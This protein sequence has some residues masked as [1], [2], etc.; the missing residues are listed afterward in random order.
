MVESGVAFRSRLLQM[1][2]GDQ[3]LFFRSSDFYAQNGFKQMSIVE[4]Y[5]LVARMR[6]T[7]RIGL[8]SQP[9][10]TSARRWIKRGILRTTII[11]QMCVIAYRLGFSDQTIARLYRRDTQKPS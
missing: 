9:V 7:G 3:A 4:D 11:N 5:E 2:Y 1:P 6:K 10:K 8:A